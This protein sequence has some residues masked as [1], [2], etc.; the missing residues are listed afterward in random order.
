MKKFLVLSCCV[1]ALAACASN[2][3]K[4]AYVAPTAVGQ[5]AVDTRPVPIRNDAAYMAK[6]ER[7]ALRRGIDLHWVNPPARPITEQ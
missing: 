1:L 4:T 3:D 7:L 6:V 2:A 5:P